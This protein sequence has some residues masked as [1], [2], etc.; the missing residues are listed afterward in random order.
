MTHAALAATPDYRAILRGVLLDPAD[1][2]PRLVLAD[3]LEETGDAAH[4]ARAEFVRLQCELGKVPPAV[5]AGYACPKCGAG[6]HWRSG[7]H[8]DH[9]KICFCGTDDAISWEP[10]VK[11][12]NPA[13]VE[14][15]LRGREMLAANETLW[16]RPWRT[17]SVVRAARTNN[18]CCNRFADR[19]SCRCL[20]DAPAFAWS[21]GFVSGVTLTQAA[22]AGGECEAVGPH[23]G[24]RCS[25]G[26]VQSPNSQFS[27]ACDAC[28]GT[29]QLPGLAE[30]LFSAHPVTAVTLGDVEPEPTGR[31][32]QW[33][34]AGGR[35]EHRAGLSVAIFDAL[36][37][38]SPPIDG[39]F[40]A[41]YATAAE[42]ATALS[43]AC[44][45]VGR[46]LAGLAPLPA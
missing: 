5:I 11:I 34:R 26:R 31:E 18:G 21:R 4:V 8:F 33:Y 15:R 38:C 2:L 27:R 19:Q 23:H 14:L 17:Q 1:D 22:F 29:G 36:P 28:R 39:R 32:Y 44:V 43:A 24:D 37:G 3:F 6:G 12:Q 10:G 25:G 30:S 41:Q 16:S 46:R 42:A 35:N 7:V 9:E 45:R 20:A 13:W 40:I